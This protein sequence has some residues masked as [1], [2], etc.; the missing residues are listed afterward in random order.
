MKLK[1]EKMNNFE[2]TKMELNVFKAFVILIGKI[3][4]YQFYACCVDKSESVQE[5]QHGCHI[6]SE[7]VGSVNKNENS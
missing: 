4:D 5:S 2:S 6:F 1:I 7:K 3:N